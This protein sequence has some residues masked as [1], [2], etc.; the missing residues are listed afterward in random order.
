MLRGHTSL[1]LAVLNSCEGART[2]PTDPFAGV[3]ETL[4]RR[5]IPAVVAMQFEVS[6]D[7]AIEFAPALYGALAAGLPIDAAVAEARKAVY[8]VSQLEWATPVLYLRADDAQLFT[9]TQLSA[10][11][12]PTGSGR[13]PRSLRPRSRTKSLAIPARRS[14]HLSGLHGGSVVLLS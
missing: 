12:S 4:V 9:I 5:G 7:A 13:P 1:R 8:T 6:D 3:A 2:D 11:P 14:I 10:A